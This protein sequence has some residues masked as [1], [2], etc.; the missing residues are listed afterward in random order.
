MINY[1]RLIFPDLD[2][3]NIC[4]KAVNRLARTKYYGTIIQ[5]SLIS[6]NDLSSGSS[7]MEIMKLTGLTLM[8]LK[9]KEEG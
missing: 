2:S 5:D 1:H 3:T 4:I 6:F 7:P 8:K 9:M